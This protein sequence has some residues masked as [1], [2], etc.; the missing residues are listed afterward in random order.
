MNDVLM[1]VIKQVPSD[2]YLQTHSTNPLL[3]TT[4]ISNAVDAFLA[5]YP[6]NDSLFSVTKKHVR[7]WDS[8]ARPLNHNQ[9]ILL[10]TQDLPPI[11]EENSCMYLFTK[12]ILERKHN[13][14]GD[15]PIMFEID[16]IEAQDIDVEINFIV[17]ELLYKHTSQK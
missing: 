13:R 16:E 15:R 12:E 2:F 7:Y 17:A 1:N 5:N 6:S 10:R 8:L 9:N 11:F 4:S 3:T 14:I